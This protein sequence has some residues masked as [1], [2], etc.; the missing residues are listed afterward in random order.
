[1]R[2]NSATAKVE[3]SQRKTMREHNN[4]GSHAGHS[5]H[6]GHD[7]GQMVAD[8]RNRF[9]VSLL[10]TIPV[11]ALSPMIQQVLGVGER[12]RFVGDT[13]I[14]TAL[15]SVIYFYGGWPFLDGL[16]EEIRARNPGMMTLVGVA[17]TAAY[18]YSVATVI[19][20]AGD[21]FFWELVTLIDIMLFGHWIEMKSVIGAGAALEK[22][23]ALMPDTAHL[24][25]S[26]GSTQEVA[27]TTLKGDERLLVKPGE[28]IPADAVIIK[29]Q[30]S[31]NESMLTGE[32]K[33]VAKQEGETVIGGA[34]NGEGAI[35][36]EVKHT[37]VESFLSGVIKLVQEA[38]ASKSRTQ[39]IANRAAFW[40]TVIA[41]SVS[42][43][44]V[45]SWL[46]FS[47]QPLA[48][49]VERAVTVLVISCPHAL[50]LAV[51][52]VVAVSTSIAAATVC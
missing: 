5:N 43:V 3:S 33:P 42:G 39:D 44:T 13:Y 34:I 19:G 24:L 32:S 38:Q 46:L 21:D 47:E 14:L 22:L 12:W 23:A 27:V 26:D 2:L 30:T 51:P 17:I 49:A 31:V 6:A 40:L 50:G 18:I 10:L 4:H 37:G 35:V 45:F 9:W 20:L 16:R 28:K 8:F 11:L 1:V 52:L 25:N 36:I 29:G 48:F 7:H 15:S 41:L